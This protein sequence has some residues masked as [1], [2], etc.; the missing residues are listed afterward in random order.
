V[1]F[2]RPPGTVRSADWLQSHVSYDAFDSGLAGGNSEWRSAHNTPI[3]R[4]LRAFR[5]W[6]HNEV[7]FSADADAEALRRWAC[8]W[9][10]TGLVIAALTFP[11]CAR[12]AV[13]VPWLHRG[14][15]GQRTV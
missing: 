6:P 3:A 2:L 14:T 9:W 1:C 12:T 4:V 11:R 7:S 10:H 15:P 13:T 8:I 5:I